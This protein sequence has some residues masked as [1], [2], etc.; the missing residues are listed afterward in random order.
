[1]R[2][3]VNEGRP[4]HTVLQGLA[5]WGLCTLAPSTVHAN[6]LILETSGLRQTH[7]NAE[8]VDS[9]RAYA[10]QPAGGHW[11]IRRLAWRGEQLWHGPWQV[12]WR[13]DEVQ[14]RGVI[15][16]YRCVI[17]CAWMSNRSLDPNAPWDAINYRLDALRLSRPDSLAWRRGAWA[18]A[19]AP[20]V[21]INHFSG[22]Q[23]GDAQTLGLSGW[24]TVGVG[25]RLDWRWGELGRM[26]WQWDG[27]GVQF[28]GVR[29]IDAQ[30]RVEWA[31]RLSPQW[32]LGLG[33]SQHHRRLTY[34]VD[35]DELKI[36]QRGRAWSVVMRAD[37]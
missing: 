4:V 14:L 15:G 25:S 13:R 16:R 29:Y 30:Q 9:T 34:A 22:S 26:T 37:W 28:K 8:M 2:D 7:A 6:Q 17:M 31:Y 3:Q 18:W 19:L 12:E 33:V 24:P 32:E 35:G 36:D 1:M 11:S 20:R 10:W 23:T 27:D 21:A 5:V